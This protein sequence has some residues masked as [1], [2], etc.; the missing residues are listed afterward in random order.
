[1]SAVPQI[2]VQEFLKQIKARRIHLEIN[3]DRIHIGWPEKTPDPEIREVIIARKP[4]IMQILKEEQPRP[5]LNQQNDLVIPF[6]SALLYLWWLPG[7]LKPSE[8]REELKRL[9][10]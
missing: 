3:G 10:N 2:P 1:M 4:E 9:V 6:E 7:G 5:Y 8:V